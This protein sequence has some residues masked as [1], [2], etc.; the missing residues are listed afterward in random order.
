MDSSEVFYTDRLAAVE[1]QNATTAFGTQILCVEH[2]T[3][4][5]SAAARRRYKVDSAILPRLLEKQIKQL[6]PNQAN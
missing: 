4:A 1:A 6:R 2:C 3:S 5:I